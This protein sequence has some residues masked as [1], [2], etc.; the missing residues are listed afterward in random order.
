MSFVD[1]EPEL[2]R[3]CWETLGAQILKERKAAD[4]KAAARAGSRNGGSGGKAGE[5]N[6]PQRSNTGGRTSKKGVV[7]APQ[8]AGGRASLGV[9]GGGVIKGGFPGVRAAHM[10]TCSHASSR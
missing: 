10:L 8:Q 9:K 4:R 1:T 5:D 3:A 2:H 6:R 7:E